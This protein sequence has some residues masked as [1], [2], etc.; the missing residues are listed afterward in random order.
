[1]QLLD[2]ISSCG[3]VTE[4]DECCYCKLIDSVDVR[5]VA[6][7][8]HLHHGFHIILI[9]SGHLRSARL[10]SNPTWL[11]MGQK[12]TTRHTK[13][14]GSA[15]TSVDF[16][17]LCQLVNVNQ[18]PWKQSSVALYLLCTT[19]I[20]R[21]QFL[22]LRSVSAVARLQS[23]QTF[24]FSWQLQH[25]LRTESPTRRSKPTD[26]RPRLNCRVLCR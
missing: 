5:D 15:A 19:R 8:H 22:R 16:H 9:L 23:I 18:P 20:P 7:Y 26:I 11:R 1:M 4:T 17:Q 13:W 25:Y 10:Q 21:R 12:L 14:K 6:V 3:P 24:Q 2:R